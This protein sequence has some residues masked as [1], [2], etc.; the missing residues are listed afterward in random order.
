MGKGL[1]GVE[2]ERKEWDGRGRE[3]HTGHVETAVE[4]V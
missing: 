4:F 2:E 1:K 3:I